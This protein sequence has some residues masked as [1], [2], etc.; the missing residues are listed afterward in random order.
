VPDRV[1]QIAG[2]VG[3]ALG[4]LEVA[5]GGA[6]ALTLWFLA[7]ALVLEHVFPWDAPLERTA[8]ALPGALELGFYAVVLVAVFAVGF[9]HGVGTAAVPLTVIAV[10]VSVFLA[11]GL[12]EAGVLYGGADAKALM[13]AGLLVPLYSVPILPIPSMAAALLAYYPFAL[14]LLMDAALFSAAVPIALG[15]RNARRGEFEFPRGF[16]GYTVPI[17]EL[18]H[19]FVWLRDPTFRRDEDEP[20]TSEDDIALRTRQ[21]EALA[22]KGVE[23]V[24]V[25]PQLPFVIL[26]FAGAVGALLAGNLVFDLAAWL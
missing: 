15:L 24:W 3:V 12:F 1:W 9:T 19:R 18:P 4:A 11:R 14:N 2:A 8:P 16:V 5:P 25:T 17:S 20:E 10:I 23:R 6:T 26:L 22:A 21:M 7:G 13:T